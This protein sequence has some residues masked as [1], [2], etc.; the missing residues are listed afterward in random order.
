VQSALL[1]CNAEQANYVAQNLPL[2]ELFFVMATQN[3]IET[4]R[5]PILLPEA[6]LD[7]FLMHLEIDYPG[8]W[9]LSL[10]IFAFNRDEAPAWPIRFEAPKL[11]PSEIYFQSTQSIIEN[12]FRR[13]LRKIFSAT[14][15]A[16]V[17]TWKFDADLA[18]G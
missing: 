7:R 10:E 2:P 5:Y 12:S 4:R 3:P 17:K 16:P 13:R 8:G 18:I 6:Q 9:D 11:K 14:I 15:I 1:E